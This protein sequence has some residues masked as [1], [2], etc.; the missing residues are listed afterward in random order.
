MII[1]KNK[2]KCICRRCRKIIDSK[3]RVVL[4]NNHNYHL[5]CYYPWLKDNYE[6]YKKN[7][8]EISKTKYKKIMILERLE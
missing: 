8:K 5:S 4:Q 6:L 7:M 2:R 3:Y 1:E